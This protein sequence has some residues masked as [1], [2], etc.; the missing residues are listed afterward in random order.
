MVGITVDE[1]GC[2]MRMRL[3]DGNDLLLFESAVFL[4]YLIGCFKPLE[5]SPEVCA[6]NCSSQNR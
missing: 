4:P 2:F 6:A 3:V 5:L 1:A